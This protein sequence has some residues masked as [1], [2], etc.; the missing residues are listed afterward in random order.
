M[1]EFN[2]LK[3]VFVKSLFLKSTKLI[4]Y[5][6]QFGCRTGIE[7]F[8]TLGEAIEIKVMLN[9]YQVTHTEQFFKLSKSYCIC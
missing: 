1:Q 6:C 3:K 5:F 9:L 8:E 7:Y 2:L 4:S